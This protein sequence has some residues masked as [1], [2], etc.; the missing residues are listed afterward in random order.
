MPQ[1]LT[2]EILDIRAQVVY[3]VDTPKPRP[4]DSDNQSCFLA[5]LVTSSLT[6]S[7]PTPH[8]WSPSSPPL[9]FDCQSPQLLVNS[10]VAAQLEKST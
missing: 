4:H 3:T 9:W 1:S 7:S 10:L 6:L 2:T 8:S 5:S